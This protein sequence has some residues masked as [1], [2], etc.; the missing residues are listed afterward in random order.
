MRALAGLALRSL[1][2]R[3]VTAGLTLLSLA[4]AVTLLI[5]VEKVRTEARDGFY[6]AVSGTDLVVGART[7]PVQLLLASVFRIGNAQAN[8]SFESF[9]LISAHPLVAWSIPLSL[10]D[11]HRGFP[12]LGT[13]DAYLEHFRYGDEA[14]LRLEDGRW[15]E[16]LEHA[17]LGAEVARRLDLAL[18]AELELTHGTRDVGFAAHDELH[19][20]VVGILAPTGTPVDRTVHVSLE[21]IEAMHHGWEA[22]VPMPGRDVD[23]HDLDPAELAPE[24]I[25]AFMLGLTSRSGLF[26][27][28]Q[29]VNRYQGEALVA[30]LPA[31]TMA[32]F[33]SLVGMAEDALLLVSAFVVLVGLAGMMTMLLAT[34]AER[35]REM[36]ILRAVGARPAH[37]LVLLVTESLLLTV[38]GACVGLLCVQGLVLVFGPLLAD[39][40]GVR[41]SPGLPT[42]REWMLVGAVVASGTLVSFVPAVTAYRRSLADGLTIRL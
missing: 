38:L 35:R 22:G 18:G 16:G 2:N 5:G 41:F 36:A 25:T 26:T 11:S 4:L 7:A 40:A 8:L 28:Q 6:A 24:Q 3:R 20:E 15:F 30:I 37:V 19:F 42:A 12:V 39:V 32:E 31:V 17:V 9:E 34:L 23:V 13:T 27:I 14:A 10:G 33:F 29:A 1:W 21:A